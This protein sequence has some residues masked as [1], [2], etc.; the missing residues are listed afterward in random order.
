MKKSMI[1]MSVVALIVGSASA[2]IVTVQAESAS[3]LGTNFVIAADAAALGGSYLTAAATRS[4]QANQIPTDEVYATFS[5]GTLGAGTTWDMYARIRVGAG[6]YDDDSFFIADQ[7]GESSVGWLLANGFQDA[8]AVGG[9]FARQNFAWVKVAGAGGFITQNAYSAGAGGD[10]KF[11]IT[12]R[13]DGLDLDTFA[14]VTAGQEVSVDGSG[15]LVA[16]PEPA[17]IGMIGI[18]GCLAIFARRRLMM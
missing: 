10:M 1:A 13:E 9:G 7:F 2:D 11:M 3:P 14:F 18:A 6:A 4:I 15:M 12:S 8:G 16:I 17:T 5:L